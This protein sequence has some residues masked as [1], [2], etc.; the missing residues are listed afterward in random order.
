[1]YEYKCVCVYVGEKEEGGGG[2]CLLYFHDLFYVQTSYNK[3]YLQVIQTRIQIN[4]L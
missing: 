3:Q 4:A 1:M 2:G